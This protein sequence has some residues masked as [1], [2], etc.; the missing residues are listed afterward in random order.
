[1]KKTAIVFALVAMMFF[2]M[3][4]ATAQEN[5]FA[6]GKIK[7]TAYVG[8]PYS[9]SHILLPPV[10]LAA[11]YGI[12][13]FGDGKFGTL[14]AGAA[15]DT[16]L[17]RFEHLNIEWQATGFASYHYFIN[18]TFEVHAKAGAGLYH[19]GFGDTHFSGIGWYEFAGISYYLSP[20]VALTAEAGYSALSYLHA[21][22][23]IV[24]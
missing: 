20:S 3:P 10:G 13:D 4:K 16:G 2:A 5:P 6:A 1:M 24:L 17:H 22:I 21:G 9:F 18:S 11:E 15:F 7:A 23:S 14:S 19:Y 12:V 8:L